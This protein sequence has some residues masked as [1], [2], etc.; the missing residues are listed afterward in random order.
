MGVIINLINLDDIPPDMNL[1]S[2]TP[3][4]L[5]AGSWELGGG[6]DEER[7]VCGV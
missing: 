2:Y 6:L 7:S 1:Y 3:L 4:E 5:G